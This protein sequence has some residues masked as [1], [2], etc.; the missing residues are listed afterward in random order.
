[1]DATTEGIGGLLLGDY[2]I[3]F[4]FA[5]VLLLAALVGAAYL[6]RRGNA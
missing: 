5:S 4:E 6:V 2:I 1:M 3:A